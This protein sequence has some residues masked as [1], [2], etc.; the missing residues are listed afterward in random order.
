MV[1]AKDCQ[2]NRVTG[3][4]KVEPTLDSKDTREKQG[5]HKTTKKEDKHAMTKLERKQ[6]HNELKRTLKQE[7]STERETEDTDS[8][9]LNAQ[10]HFKRYTVEERKVILQH[11][12]REP[13]KPGESYDG[14]KNSKQVNLS[15]ENI[16]EPKL[17]WIALELE[18][19]EEKLLIETL[20]NYKDVFAWSY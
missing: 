18:E 13:Q 2:K 17:V 16:E 7:W 3:Y 20:K 6:K 9:V 19:H 12:R 15:G 10:S 14:P 1:K 4:Y 11:P 8:G 5:I